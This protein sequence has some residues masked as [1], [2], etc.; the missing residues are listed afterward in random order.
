MSSRK[1]SLYKKAFEFL[2]DE[3]L[4][5]PKRLVSD[6]EFAM[7]DAAVEVWPDIDTSGCVFHYRQAIRRN[8]M[9]KVKEKPTDV[10]T[11]S[12]HFK[13]KLMFYNLQF[14][15]SGKIMRGC[16]RILAKQREYNLDREFLEMNEYFERFW[17]NRVTPERF[18][19]YRV[20]H[21]TDNFN[22]SMNAKM[23]RYLYKHPTYSIF[24]NFMKTAMTF[25]NQKILTRQPYVQQSKMTD[26]LNDAWTS[27]ENKTISIR[28][29]LQKD[30]GGK[31]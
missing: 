12:Q 7:R 26:N 16:R 30:Y 21:R 19:M 3:L 17:L 20:T 27:L 11:R 18:S 15:P 25:E 6:Y 8:Y 29:F 14:L 5:N 1:K 4:L 2:R 24:F 9:S 10:F 23:G 13:I 31:N 22:E 28:D